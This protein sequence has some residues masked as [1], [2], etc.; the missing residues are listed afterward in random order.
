MKFIVIGLGYFG[1]TLAS[2]LTSMG[3]EVLGV[4]N[5]P[6]QVDEHKDAITYVM[7]MDTTIVKAVESLPLEDADAVIVAIGE[8]VG[9]SILTVSILKNLGVKRIIGRVISPVHQNILHQIGITETIH[10]EKETA[11]L[12][13]ST[14]RIRN[15]LR[16]ID[17]NEENALAELP[18]ARKYVGHTIDSMNVEKRFGIK[19]VA[20]KKTT[21]TSFLT[22]FSKNAWSINFKCEPETVLAENDI[23]LVAGTINNIRNFSES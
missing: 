3:H 7:Q 19:L 15:A 14:L 21:K 22:A 5:R 18:V 11:L 20:V 12:V 8:D 1:S 23:L 10:P 4:D 16:I 9:S 17:L 2:T 6:E 13:S